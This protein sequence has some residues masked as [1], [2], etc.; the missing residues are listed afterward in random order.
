MSYAGPASRGKRALEITPPALGSARAAGSTRPKQLKQSSRPNQTY[1][2]SQG[3]STVFAAGLALGVF[4]GA[5]AALL[6]APQAGADTRRPLVRRGRRLTR[7]GRDSWDD[8]RDELRRVSTR[9]RRRKAL[10]EL[11]EDL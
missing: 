9:R 10:E 5:G 4:I 11:N 3:S 1:G 2:E 7:R 8:L 6:L